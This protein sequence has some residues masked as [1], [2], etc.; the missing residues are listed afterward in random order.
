M[1]YLVYY[2]IIKVI[3]KNSISEKKVWQW[4]SNQVYISLL[5]NSNNIFLSQ[6]CTILKF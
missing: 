6:A 2:K 1:T 4:N 5:N 3:E